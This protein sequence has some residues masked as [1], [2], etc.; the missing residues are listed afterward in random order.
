[1]DDKPIKII[2]TSE[3]THI[4]YKTDNHTWQTHN[5]ETHLCHSNMDDK[6]LPLKRYL[7]DLRPEITS[8]YIWGGGGG[9]IVFTCTIN[10]KI[11]S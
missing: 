3:T 1:M 9:V 8:K 11:E 6:H 10:D 5:T 4:I 2:N 7:I